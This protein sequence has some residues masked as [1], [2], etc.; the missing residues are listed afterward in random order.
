MLDGLSREVVLRV[1]RDARLRTVMNMACQ[2]FGL[3]RAHTMFTVND[4][5][6]GSLDTPASAG[7]E[8][9]DVLLAVEVQDEVQ[10]V[11]PQQAPAGAARE[12]AA[13]PP[14]KVPESPA[15]A[16]QP[17]GPS[18]STPRRSSNA[19]NTTDATK[20]LVK[21]YRLAKDGIVD[22]L[23]QINSD[24]VDWLNKMDQRVST[25]LTA[26][27]KKSELDRK[28]PKAAAKAFVAGKVGGAR[29]DLWKYVGDC[30]E[31]VKTLMGK[32]PQEDTAASKKHELELT[33]KMAYK[34]RRWMA[35]AERSLPRDV[36][37]LP[38]LVPQQT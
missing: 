15:A 3:D 24:V 38:K 27:V 28:L 9:G 4:Q 25:E 1:G 13:E 31:E 19:T 33:E 20:A 23:H 11:P 10:D 17:A 6:V 5:R 21:A 36:G 30:R 18:S 29:S 37:S 22:T 35:D 16:A 12:P 7:L 2:R 32:G 26:L 34:V 8:H 14:A